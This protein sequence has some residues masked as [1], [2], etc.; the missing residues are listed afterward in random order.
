MSLPPGGPLGSSSECAVWTEGIWAGR[1]GDGRKGRRLRGQPAGWVTRPLVHCMREPLR[2]ARQSVLRLNGYGQHPPTRSNSKSP[3]TPVAPDQLAAAA[4]RS[5]GA[6]SLS[7][8]APDPVASDA[9]LAR[10]PVPAS[11][12]RR[13]VFARWRGRPP[14]WATGGRGLQQLGPCGL[15]LQRRIEVD[16]L[17]GDENERAWRGSMWPAVA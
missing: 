14:T 9:D 11:S 5:M 2:H 8:G 10:K 13:P 3:H 1:K 12:P 16:H 15:P 4:S 17:L 7:A 6:G